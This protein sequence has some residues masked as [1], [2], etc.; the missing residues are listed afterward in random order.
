MGVQIEHVG[1]VAVVTAGG[2]FVGGG[3][4]DELDSALTRLIVQEGQRKTLLNLAEARIMSSMALGVL[5]K[6]QTAVRERQGHFILCAPR[7]RLKL[8]ISRCFG[9][10]IQMYD[11]QEEALKRLQEL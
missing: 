1:D 11:S 4:T 9:S 6:T 10:V 8:V 7:P 2:Q 3:E 5:V